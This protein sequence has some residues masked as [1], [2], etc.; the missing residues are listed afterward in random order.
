M[1]KGSACECMY[2]APCIRGKGVVTPWASWAPEAAKQLQPFSFWYA[3][4]HSL[5]STLLLNSLLLPAGAWQ[6]LLCYHSS[7]HNMTEGST[8][9][10]VSTPAGPLQ[11]MVNICTLK[12]GTGPGR[13]RT[14]LSM[15]HGRYNL[16]HLGRLPASVQ[17][18]THLSI[19]W[20]FS[21]PS[22]CGPN[23]RLKRSSN[24]HDMLPGK[25][26]AKATPIKSE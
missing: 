14:I 7:M 10:G 9:G 5:L 23:Y 24:H 8:A 11:K 2:I 21:L 3:G 22:S 13:M 1:I 18:W 16:M 4:L 17:G 19:A 15:D 26:H 20:T 12:R 25:Q 6:P